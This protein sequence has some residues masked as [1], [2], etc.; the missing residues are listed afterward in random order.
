MDLPKAY[1]SAALRFA[2]VYCAGIA[3]AC[4]GPERATPD[5]I[6][7]MSLFGSVFDT[8]KSDYV[9]EVD[10]QDLIEAAVEGMLSSLDPHSGYLSSRDFK[11]MKVN[12]KGEFGGLGIEVTMDNGLVK[13][14]S[15]IDDT[16]AY[17][18]GIKAGDYISR[19][20]DTAVFG[21]SL[22]ESIDLM[23]GAPGS[24]ISL[25][26]LRKGESE[27]LD[28]RVVRDIIRIESVKGSLKVLDVAYVRITSFSENTAPSVED[29]LQEITEQLE[30]GNKISGMVLDLRNNPGG[31]LDQA[32]A[33]TD[34]FLDRGEI[35]SI[36]GRLPNSSQRYNA[37]SGD[38]LKGKPI[39]VL[40]NIGT[41]SASEIVS[42]ALQD[43]RRAIV[44]GERSFGK[45]S[46]QTVL[47]LTA[48]GGGAMR[49]TTSRYYTPSGRSIQAGGIEPDIVI[50]QRSLSKEDE[51]KKSRMNTSEEL[52]H[53]HLERE[54]DIDTTYEKKKELTY[55]LNNK[56]YQDDYQLGRAIDLLHAMQWLKKN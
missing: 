12:T 42:G 33:V 11:E 8:I 14:V 39:V 54:Q 25:E 40:V 49:L 9:E 44:V 4:A 13:V 36:G 46:V 51:E 34:L 10:N 28:V 26:I 30:E 31:L 47:P 16:P 6:A 37:R 7:L 22:R 17:R 27:P 2:L 48:T 38:V 1:C 56:I 52:L 35:V 23:R 45:G 3:T 32:V 50:R 5:T 53:R 29:V 15:P 19:I 20:D 41:A 55:H 21:M 18:A 24:E 43:H